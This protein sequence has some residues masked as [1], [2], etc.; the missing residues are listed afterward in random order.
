MFSAIIAYIILVQSQLI[1]ALENHRDILVVVIQKPTYEKPKKQ[2]I[3][4]SIPEEHVV[5]PT[6]ITD[7][8]PVRKPEPPKE[9]LQGDLNNDGCVGMEDLSLVESNW[10]R[11]GDDIKAGDTNK[12]GIVNMEDLA[13]V[14]KEWGRCI[15]EGGD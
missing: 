8:P 12:D 3:Q 1:E 5:Y 14:E 2:I 6:P 11:I 4:E 7:P 10:G 9:V 15:K 13:I